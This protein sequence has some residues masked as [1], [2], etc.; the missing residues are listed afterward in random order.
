M[1]CGLFVDK[2]IYFSL[3]PYIIIRY[4]TIIFNVPAVYDVGAGI[5]GLA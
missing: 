3:I 5:K 1:F 2:F 4:I